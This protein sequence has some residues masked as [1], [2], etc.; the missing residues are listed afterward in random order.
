MPSYLANSGM[1]MCSYPKPVIS[2]RY[3]TI[4]KLC[5]FRGFSCCGCN[6]ADGQLSKGRHTAKILCLKIQTIEKITR[7]KT[8][9]ICPESKVPSWY[10]LNTGCFACGVQCVRLTT[11]DL[12][13]MLCA[14][15]LC[16][17]AGHPRQDYAHTTNL[18][19]SHE[20]D[21]DRLSQE[22][23]AKENSFPNGKGANTR[24]EHHS[25]DKPQGGSHGKGSAPSAAPP[26][27]RAGVSEQTKQNTSAA[28]SKNGK[29]PASNVAP[30]VEPAAPSNPFARKTKAAKS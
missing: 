30:A 19:P 22:K 1:S 3:R 18:D 21:D 4:V 14:P 15:C 24:P 28:G 11:W 17:S 16:R 9:H 10:C 26:L 29:R 27:K 23:A 25:G 20:D 7:P 12:K 2:F 6:V 13:L 5:P 8:V